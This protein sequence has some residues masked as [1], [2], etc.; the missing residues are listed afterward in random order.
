MVSEST[1]TYLVFGT[2]ANLAASLPGFLGLGAE[3]VDEQRYQGTRSR[4]HGGMA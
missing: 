4:E 2:R 3:E 1:A